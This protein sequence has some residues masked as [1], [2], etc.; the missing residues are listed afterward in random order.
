MNGNFF[1]SALIISIIMSILVSA[2]SLKKG[3]S[4]KSLIKYSTL[5]SLIFIPIVGL[6]TGTF[7]SHG[8]DIPW[9]VFGVINSLSII[10]MSCFTLMIYQIFEKKHNE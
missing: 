9:W 7:Y 8:F 4:G 2:I 6:G 10:L 3:R 1:I 5:V